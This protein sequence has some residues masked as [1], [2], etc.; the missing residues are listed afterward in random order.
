MLLLGVGL[1]FAEGVHMLGDRVQV[2]TL[3]RPEDLAWR[4]MADQARQ[5]CKGGKYPVEVHVGVGVLHQL[6]DDVMG[7]SLTQIKSVRLFVS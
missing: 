5:S 2:Q 4:V 6:H 3:A 1:L 7:Y